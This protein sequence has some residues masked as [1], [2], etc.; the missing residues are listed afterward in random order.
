MKRT[1]LA[2][3]LVEQQLMKKRD[4]CRVCDGHLK[5][6]L[7]LGNQYIS[8]FVDEPEQ[9]K[10]PAA[11]LILCQCVSCSLVQL[12]DT[13]PRDWLYQ[14]QYWYKS[15]INESMVAAL[16]DVVNS[17]FDHVSSIG[18]TDTVIDIGANDGTLLGLYGPCWEVSKEHLPH[19]IAFEPAFT[20]HEELA[21]HCEIM[22]PDYF[23]PKTGYDGPKAKIITSIAM[24]YDLED[25]N[26]FVA[27]IKRILHPEGVWVIQLGDLASMIESNGFDTICHEHLE[28][29]SLETLTCLLSRHRLLPFH[30]ET[31]AVNGGSIRVF[32]K[33]QADFT[34]EL[35][36]TIEEQLLRE[37]G[38]KLDTQVPW[39]NLGKLTQGI[40]SDV[41]D[42][43]LN[44]LQHGRPVD[45]YGASTK[46]NTL[47]QYFELDHT[48]IRRAIE[49]SPAKWGKFTTGTWIPIV[50][51]EQGRRGATA[52][53][54]VPIW[55]F[56]DGIVAREAEYLKRGQMLFPLPQVQVVGPD[57]G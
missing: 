10:Y 54:L 15:G 39:E 24:F 9:P 21:Q 35:D 46:G 52:L 17:L 36:D 38:L 37:A 4:T 41:R 43:I 7:S 49:R 1:L 50:S 20:L 31:N 16:A 34:R 29:Y 6:I 14:E 8:D 11:P 5:Q 32:V 23:P 19:R 33:H 18:E 22:V 30:C 47:L 28:Y 2:S 45:V 13:V 44:E 12:R 27:E 26:A 56:K 48:M 42:I 53:W 40:R 3:K 51:E 25:P 55:H 57:N